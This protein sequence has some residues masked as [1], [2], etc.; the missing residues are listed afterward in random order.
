MSCVNPNCT[1]K[2]SDSKERFIS[3]WLCDDVWHA[4]CATI[5]GR[6]LDLLNDTEKGLYWCCRNCRQVSVAFYKHFKNS[7][8]EMEAI[9]S[10]LTAVLTRY[11]KFKESVANCPELEKICVSPKNRSPKRKKSTVELSIPSAF[12]NPCS[13]NLIDMDAASPMPSC[14]Q[15]NI[16]V[17]P[18]NIL[19]EPLNE[20]VSGL[21]NINLK[22]IASNNKSTVET[23]AIPGGLKIV[24]PRKTVFV[25]R[26]AP[27]TT[28]DDIM[29]YVLSK[30][31]PD[32]DVVCRKINSTQTRISSFKIVVNDEVFD[33]LVD[34]N[35]WPPKAFVKEFV[36][37]ERRDNVAR[38][39]SDNNNNAYSKN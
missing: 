12:Q 37:Y 39:P 16:E 15:Q 19:T 35:F 26:F 10:D 14:S 25:S 32:A 22:T 23:K 38:I 9:K 8:M 18:S 28:A 17:P 6:T 27:E 34:I 24:P 5:T 1:V 4:K 29:Q 13:P 2:S 11:E 3:C 33:R 30:L 21:P 7:T 31:D 20:N 36:Y